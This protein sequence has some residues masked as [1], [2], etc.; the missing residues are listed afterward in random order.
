[1]EGFEKEIVYA[2][3]F[4]RPVNKLAL[5]VLFYWIFL[6]LFYINIAPF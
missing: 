5:S 2:A 4:V 1:M 6:P 3:Q